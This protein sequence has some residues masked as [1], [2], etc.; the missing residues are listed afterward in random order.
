MS[1]L[2]FAVKMQPFPELQIAV[3]FK[4]AIQ[5]YLESQHL[6]LMLLVVL[7]VT[8]HLT[9]SICI[10]KALFLKTS[11]TLASM[12]TSL[13]DTEINT[14]IHLLFS[15]SFFPSTYRFLGTIF[16][17]SQFRKERQFSLAL[18]CPF[19]LV[20]MKTNSTQLGLFCSLNETDGKLAVLVRVP[21]F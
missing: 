3:K 18:Q 6:F 21:R 19:S 17:V 7:G 15:R 2:F 13:D 5:A 11:K 9:E 1:K 20:L 16:C 4:K 10:R 14:Q 8:Y 12:Y